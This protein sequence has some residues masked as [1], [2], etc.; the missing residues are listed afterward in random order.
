MRSS[1][2]TAGHRANKSSKVRGM[3][4]VL[5]AHDK[6][7]RCSLVKCETAGKDRG[8]R[9]LI[10]YICLSAAYAPNIM[11][12]HPIPEFKAN[13]GF[14]KVRSFSYIL[15]HSCRCFSAVALTAN[16]LRRRWCRQMEL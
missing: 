2:G 3:K 16:T 9:K 6:T 13:V 14:A 5:F 10:K 4:A 8:G 12:T 15:S 1:S 7:H 11:Q